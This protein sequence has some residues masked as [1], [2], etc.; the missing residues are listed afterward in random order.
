MSR[1]KKGDTAAKKK[2]TTEKKVEAA[3]TV[4]GQ[5]QAEKTDSQP[6]QVEMPVQVQPKTPAKEEV[7]EPKPQNLPKEDEIE[8]KYKVSDEDTRKML[9]YVGI[10]SIPRYQNNAVWITAI[11]KVLKTDTS[12]SWV[13]LKRKTAKKYIIE[14]IFGHCSAIKKVGT[15]IPIEAIPMEYSASFPR[16]SIYEMARFIADYK[17]R[18]VEQYQNR[19]LE[20]LTETMLDIQIEMYY[21]DVKSK[22]I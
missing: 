9:N 17:H 1:P 5:P 12:V 6:E 19:P 3:G 16:T 7:S 11:A 21:N 2:K 8:V 13:V 18:P 20:E 4:I 14:K 15:P 10:T 22:K